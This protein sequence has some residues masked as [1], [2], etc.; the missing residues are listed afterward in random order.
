MLPDFQQALAE[1]TAFPELCGA[2]RNDPTLLSSRYRLTPR[3]A[4]QLEAVAGHPAMDCVCGLYRMNR[5]GPLVL[6][7]SGTLDALGPWLEP[8]L[9]AYWREHPWAYTQAY[10]ECER[11]CSWLRGRQEA[12]PTLSPLQLA[13]L[14]REEADLQE[15]IH[16]ITGDGLCSS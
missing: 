9:L 7:L 14:E 12:D 16:E 13:V 1:I 3:E 5:L 15:A 4:R 2:V 6:N 8:V 10:P 11:F